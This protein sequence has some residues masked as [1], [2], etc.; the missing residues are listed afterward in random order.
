M[1]T[2]K[3]HP[4][5]PP[6]QRDPSAGPRKRRGSPRLPVK[7]KRRRGRPKTTR[8]TGGL[9]QIE[10]L[11]ELLADFR[12]AV[13]FVTSLSPPPIGSRQLSPDGC[14]FDLDPDDMRDMQTLCRQ[15]VLLLNGPDQ[16]A[17]DPPS[18]I[19]RRIP[20]PDYS[21]APTAAERAE[22][23]ATQVLVGLIHDVADLCDRI[24]EAGLGNR[25]KKCPTCEL[26]LFDLTRP[27]NT[28]WH[29]ECAPHKLKKLT[30]K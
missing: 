27:R 8:A 12:D 28:R 18:V 13:A 22:I 9:T 15:V 5:G 17:I 25:V 26:P 20:F 2:S 30:E 10:T 23:G 11:R 4:G 1:P 16:E 7:G 24:A 14:S 21:R 3:V 19:L 6:E 29:P